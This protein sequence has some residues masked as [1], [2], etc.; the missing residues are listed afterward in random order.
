MSIVEE[1]IGS[2]VLY[3]TQ[4]SPQLD[5]MAYILIVVS[6]YLSEYTNYYKHTTTRVPHTVIRYTKRSQIL[7]ILQS[8]R[9]SVR[10]N[11]TTHKSNCNKN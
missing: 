7:S 3:Q 2:V 11:R 1:K 5:I 10:E 9:M 4:T 8:Q 6:G